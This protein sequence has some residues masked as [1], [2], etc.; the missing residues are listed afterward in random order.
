MTD[1]ER[2]PRNREA[3]RQLVPLARI[4]I[5]H[6]TQFRR[7][8]DPRHVEE[9]VA[10]RERGVRFT[11]DPELYLDDDGS[12]WVGDGFHRLEADR[13]LGHERV[14]AS[15]RPG[16]RLDAMIHAGGANGGH[17]LRRDHLYVRKAICAFLDHEELG[18]LSNRTIAKLVRCDHKTVGTVREEM[19]RK[20]D[21][22]TYTTKHGTEAV[23]H[24]ANL[25]GRTVGA[26]GKVNT[27][28]ELPRPIQ[29]T[30]RRLVDDAGSWSKRDWAFARSWL[31][32]LPPTP[33][34]VRELGTT[35]DLEASGTETDVLKSEEGGENEIKF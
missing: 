13:R 30:L 14:W 27:F 26:A 20:S 31:T 3:K 4:E 5:D 15:V 21:T 6:S 10:L 28:H 2:D 1:A 29:G 11:D 16:T 18:R 24:T 25:R 34:G 32:Q 8:K 22:C 12:Y 7:R 9:L 33:K 19:G 23:M 17:G 35:L